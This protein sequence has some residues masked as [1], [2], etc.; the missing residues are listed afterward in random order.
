MIRIPRWAVIGVLLALSGCAKQYVLTEIVFDVESLRDKPAEV[1]VTDAYRRRIAEI[2]ALAIR[3]PDSCQRESGSS[4]AGGAR[5]EASIFETNCG[6]WMGEVERAMTRTGY[7]VISWDALHNLERSESLS[8][9]VAAQRLGADAVLLINSMEELKTTG[10]NLRT[11]QFGYYESNPNGDKVRQLPLAEEDR[12]VLRTLTEQDVQHVMVDKWKN[13]AV[14]A[15]LDATVVLAATGENIWQFRGRRVERFGAA[16]GGRLLFRGRGS[17]YRPVVT[18]TNAALAALS[19][20]E[21]LSVDQS[22]LKTDERDA[23]KETRL[24]LFR[25]LAADFASQFRSG[26]R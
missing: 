25:A 23:Y 20:N 6:T 12:K 4:V 13:V 14:G 21:L 9:Y 3:M 22:S 5:G 24:R 19:T 8:T 7:R 17:F 11:K 18:R 1:I 15:G 16:E 26:T 10:E 2:G